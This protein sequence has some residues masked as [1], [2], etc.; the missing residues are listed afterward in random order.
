MGCHTYRVLF[1]EKE[2]EIINDDEINIINNFENP[3][4]LIKDFN[5][6]SSTSNI[7]ITP[8]KVIPNVVF[9]PSQA[10]F[11]LPVSSWFNLRASSFP[12]P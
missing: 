7:L 5:D 3:L 9:N 6:Y 4:T 11:N 2:N 12:V 1:E 10:S 8:N